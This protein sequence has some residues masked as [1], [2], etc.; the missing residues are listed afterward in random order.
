MGGG[1]RVFVRA[2]YKYY[3]YWIKAELFELYNYLPIKSYIS[4]TNLA[5]IKTVRKPQL[6]LI[7]KQAH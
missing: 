5:T 7:I 3:I 4:T 2:H 1:E 6:P